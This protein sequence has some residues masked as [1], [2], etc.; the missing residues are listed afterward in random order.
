MGILTTTVR[1]TEQYVE[2]A[3]RPLNGRVVVAVV[4]VVVVVVV[5]AA[6]AAAVA[7]VVVVVVEVVV[8]VV[9]PVRSGA[10]NEPARSGAGNERLLVVR[11]VR[12]SQATLIPLLLMSG[13][14]F[15]HMVSVAPM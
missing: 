6:A 7:V 10:G 14:R 4:V 11:G 15:K 8:A 3:K 9:V 1:S 2:I 13:S 12:Q 5:A